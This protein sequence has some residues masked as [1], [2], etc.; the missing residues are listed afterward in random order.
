MSMTKSM[1][2]LVC[3]TLTLA[4]ASPALAWSQ[5][6]D[7]ERP[8]S[9]LVF[10]K[11][12]R[13]T[14]ADAAVTANAVH[15][16]TELEISVRCPD[17][18]TCTDGQEVRMRAHWVCPGCTE[19]SF[20]LKTTVNGS[21]YFN[22]EG[23]SV[24]TDPVLGIPVAT[25]AAFP[26]NATT[27]IPTPLCPRGYLIV[28]VID[29][30]SA[31]NP[32]KFDGLIGDA[33][34][35]DG[36]TVNPSNSA[37]AYNAVPI[38]ASENL[39]PDALTDDQANGGDGD[40]NLDFNGSEYQRLTG[41]I[42]GTV[43]YEDQITTGGTAETDLTLLTLDVRS[44]LPD[45]PTTTV[46]LNFYSTDEGICDAAV[47]FLCWTERPL[48][49]TTDVTN[50]PIDASFIEARMGRKGLVE[51]D[52]PATQYNFATGETTNATVLGIVYTREGTGVAA[53]FANFRD[54]A[55]SLYHD[56]DPVETEF[57]P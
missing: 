45:N 15:A 7:S 54:Y 30:S 37:R 28:W 23:V 43:R 55:Y 21:L 50:P 27:V 20:N 8:G 17:G 25:A 34:L 24:V 39:G 48:G 51:S 5:V 53:A 11:F 47:S 12:I 32:I 3:S 57:V 29:D 16:R 41:R 19:N 52:G 31:G 38:Q 9:V 33:I 6:N 2:F 46:K 22:T 10:P 49:R 1:S 35:R 40:G 18:A 26:S 44:N 14:F 36:T 4:L 13:G 42:F 56:G